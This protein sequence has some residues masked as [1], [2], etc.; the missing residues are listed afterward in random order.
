[1]RPDNQECLIYLPGERSNL[2][3][4]FKY[5]AYQACLSLSPCYLPRLFVS[6]VVTKI[7][8]GQGFAECY[9]IIYAFC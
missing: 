6:T 1:M 2:S 5:K 7:G 3:I 4:K 8:S 9:T